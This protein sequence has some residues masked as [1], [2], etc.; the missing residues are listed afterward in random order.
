MARNEAVGRARF[1]T[2]VDASGVKK[3]LDEAKRR[4][5][6][7]GDQTEHSFAR[8]STSALGRFSQSVD[9]IV[10]RFNRIAQSGGIGGAILGGIGLGAGLSTFNMV[11]GAITGAL[12]RI[13]QGIELASNKA[14][15]A[16]KANILFGDSYGIIEEASRGAATSVG[17]SSG[18]YLAAAGNVANLVTNFGIAGREAAEMSR[19]IVQ[20]SA[21]MGSFN[22]ASTDEVV[23]AI[24]AAFRGETEPIR[25]FGVMLDAAT[26]ASKAVAMGLAES[27]R[28]V[29]NEAKARATYQLI[30]E[31]TTAAQG[32]FARTSE[33]Y[34]N[35]QRIAAAKTEEALTRLGEAIM[36]LAQELMPLLA[37]AG[38][39]VVDILTGLIGIARDL[40]TVARDLMELWNPQS[41]EIRLAREEVAKW[42]DELERMPE[43]AG[44]ARGELEGI[45]RN[46][47]AAGTGLAGAKEELIDLARWTDVIERG[48]SS[49]HG[50]VRNFE[51]WTRWVEQGTITADEFDRK[52][53]AMVN[54]GGLQEL[55]DNL[56][57]LPPELAKVVESINSG[58]D[59]IDRFVDS[60]YRLSK[61]MPGGGTQWSQFL[62][63]NADLIREHWMRMPE[64][65][66]QALKHTGLVVQTGV[67]DM[68]D[69]LQKRFVNSMEG[70]WTGDGYRALVPPDSALEA[71]R[72]GAQALVSAMRIDFSGA[73]S[74]G[75]RVQ[76][77]VNAVVRAIGG[78]G[79]NFREELRNVRRETRQGMEQVLEALT[80]PTGF[81]RT[82]RIVEDN[83]DELYRQRARA[84]R[85]GNEVEVAIIDNGIAQQVGLW[86]RATGQSY[87]YGQR[88]TRQHGRGMRSG[89]PYV[90]D[91]AEA[92]AAAAGR[93]LKNLPDQGFTWGSRYAQMLV[94]GML[95]RVDEVAAAAGSLSRATSNQN[96]ISSPAKEGPWSEGGGPEGWGRR[97]GQMLARG[98]RT[99]RFDVASAAGELASMAPSLTGYTLTAGARQTVTHEHHGRVQVELSPS[100]IAAARGQGASWEDVGRMASAVNRIDEVLTAAQRTAG[101]RY[102]GPVGGTI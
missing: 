2:E 31:Q 102:L 100:T 99:A 28:A 76:G 15:A 20:L 48:G 97:Y 35:S 36:P 38:I 94:R 88:I 27:T 54:N 65:I 56:D 74:W 68:V 47:Q 70:F 30:L 52:V 78:L 4:I 50:M 32:D 71:V 9:G 98:M 60:F 13:G 90:S 69:P 44:R 93:P 12:D 16:S 6:E 17:L 83:L 24:G 26:V 40:G 5:K 85:Q 89:I 59:A 53:R 63:N 80:N 7:T 25:R 67:A 82:L 14:E 34:A 86:E 96:R 37:E 73:D 81:K 8:Q 101:T 77:G 33:G 95:S 55:A 61:E 87:A 58:D 39:A 91:A 46:A 75:P 62:V 1:E 23:E 18:A 49:L 42:T 19:D 10:G 21:D 72:Q 57:L 66:R 79:P 11:Q 45:A 29:N 43:A 41:K 92:S 22:N 51:M 3:G 84:A 64:D